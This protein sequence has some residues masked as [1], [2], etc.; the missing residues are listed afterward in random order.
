MDTTVNKKEDDVVDQIPPH[1]QL[2]E[3]ILN[4]ICD[5]VTK[6]NLNLYTVVGVLDNIKFNLLQKL[7]DARDSDD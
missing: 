3:S 7:K 4:C 5:C 2:E 6:D 1:I